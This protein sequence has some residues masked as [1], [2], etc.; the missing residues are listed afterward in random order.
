LSIYI[1]EEYV[2][3]FF[4]SFIKSYYLG[5]N[6]HSCARLFNIAPYSVFK[7]QKKEDRVMEN[8]KLPPVPRDKLDRQYVLLTK[9]FDSIPPKSGKI[10]KSIVFHPFTNKPREN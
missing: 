1:I 6:I 5:L 10:K 2:Y 7:A 4:I 3:I 8:M 9:F